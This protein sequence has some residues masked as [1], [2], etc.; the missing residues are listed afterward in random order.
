MESR[1]HWHPHLLRAEHFSTSVL[2]AT[3]TTGRTRH[4][5]LSRK[6]DQHFILATSSTTS[7]WCIKTAAESRTQIRIL[8]KNP[9]GEIGGLL[10]FL[11]R[12]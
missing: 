12:R 11:V 2:Q 1:R 4:P 8:E 6:C 9:R 10:I 7:R 5:S 3:G